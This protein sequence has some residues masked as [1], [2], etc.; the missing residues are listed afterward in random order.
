MPKRKDPKTKNSTHQRV[1]S[2]H[3]NNHP[4]EIQKSDTIRGYHVH[5]RNTLHKYNLKTPKIHDGRT[6]R[7]RRGNNTTII[8]IQNQT[9]INAAVIQGNK[10]PYRRSIN[11]HHK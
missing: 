5:Q 8:Y 11:L 9:G 4:R 6:H 3:T 7:Q 2:T 10:H 1:N